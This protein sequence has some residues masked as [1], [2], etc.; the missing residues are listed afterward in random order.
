M[1]DDRELN[2]FIDSA[3]STYAEPRDGLQAR[4]LANL[5]VSPTRRSRLPWIIALPI[6]ACLLLLLM[7]SPRHNRTE[8]VQ[9]A[10]RN[11]A[12]QTQSVPQDSIAQATQV[13]AHHRQPRVPVAHA[14]HKA[15]APAPPKLDVFPTPHPISSQEQAL[16]HYVVNIPESDR[17]AL[18]AAQDQPIAPLTIAVIQIQPIKSSDPLDKSEN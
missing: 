4:I 8:P 2:N 13:P 17:R 15:P 3:L 11:P 9:Q 10:K 18:A 1:P 7:L 12:S 14:T 16:V 6:A 5:S